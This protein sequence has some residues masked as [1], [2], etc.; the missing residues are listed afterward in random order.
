MTWWVQR[1][2]A[3]DVQPATCSRTHVGLSSGPIALKLGRF[4]RRSS[5]DPM[6]HPQQLPPSWATNLSPVRT[7]EAVRLVPPAAE[8]RHRLT[9]QYGAATAGVSE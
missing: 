2:R 7:I 9:P 1:A 4:S 8:G 6:F 3:Q 5:Q